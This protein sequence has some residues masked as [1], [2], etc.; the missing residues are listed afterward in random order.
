MKKGRI[1]NFEIL[2]DTNEGLVS[3]AEKYI[4][5]DIQKACLLYTSPSPRD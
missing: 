4:P 2:W 5:T 3:L 1:L